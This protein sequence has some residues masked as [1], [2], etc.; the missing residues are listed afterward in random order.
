MIVDIVETSHQEDMHGGSLLVQLRQ[1]QTPFETHVDRSQGLGA[2][3]VGYLV[4]AGT[5]LEQDTR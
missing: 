4:A 2:D 3:V 1:P 5:A